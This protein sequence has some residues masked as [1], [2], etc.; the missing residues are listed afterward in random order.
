MAKKQKNESV[1]KKM[2]DKRSA[3]IAADDDVQEELEG[4]AEK[5]T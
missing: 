2:N 1:I 4:I 5:G 3:I